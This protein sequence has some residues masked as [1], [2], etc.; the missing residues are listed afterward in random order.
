MGQ[1]KNKNPKTRPRTAIIN[2]KD[3][4]SLSL[5]YLPKRF[6]V[7]GWW[8]KHCFNFKKEENSRKEEEKN[9]FFYLRL[10]RG[11]L[12][13]LG[14]GLADLAGGHRRGA[15]GRVDAEGR[16]RRGDAARDDEGEDLTGVFSRFFFREIF[17]VF[18]FSF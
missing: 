6:K 12:G 11:G 15:V 2:Q 18:S 8:W 14:R 3:I 1:S 16:D 17:L 5:F 4:E 10:G 13:G 9:F 7:V